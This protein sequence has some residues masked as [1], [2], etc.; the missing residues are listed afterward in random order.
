MTKISA[1]VP[2]PRNS[3]R[4]K[5]AENISQMISDGIQND[6]QSQKCILGSSNDILLQQSQISST[7][8]L[9][10]LAGKLAFIINLSYHT[11]I[12]NIQIIKEHERNK[13]KNKVTK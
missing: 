5:G 6:S 7:V 1:G 4:K 12:S 2:L 9:L 8:P 13:K 3:H 10:T 11:N